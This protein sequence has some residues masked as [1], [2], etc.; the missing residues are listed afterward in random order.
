MMGAPDIDYRPCGMCEALVS[1]AEGCRHWKPGNV[2]IKR[3]GWTRGRA[4]DYK[5]ERLKC[6]CGKD[7]T[8]PG[9]PF[10]HATWCNKSGVD[11]ESSGTIQ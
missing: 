9:P 3:H 5:A 11:T 6:S 2:G 10:P 1:T 4:R 7:Q 8:N